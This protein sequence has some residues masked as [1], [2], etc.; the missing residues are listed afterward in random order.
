[1]SI[2]LKISEER[3]KRKQIASL[4]NRVMDRVDEHLREIRGILSMENKDKK[5]IY[6]CIYP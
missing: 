5:N 1:M 3:E 2:D 4:L 6:Y